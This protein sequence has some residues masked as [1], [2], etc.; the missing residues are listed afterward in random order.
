MISTGVTIDTEAAMTAANPL[1]KDDDV[2][3]DDDE[4]DDDDDE[5]AEGGPKFPSV[6]EPALCVDGDG[7]ETT[8]AAVAAVREAAASRK[9]KR[10]TAMLL[11]K[12]ME[13]LDEIWMRDNPVRNDEDGNPVD[14]AAG[15]AGND[16]GGG[17]EKQPDESSTTT[18]HDLRGEI[19]LPP[20]DMDRIRRTT[21][22]LVRVFREDIHGPAVRALASNEGLAEEKSRLEA[23]LAAARKDVDRLR[24]T[25]LRSR[26]TIQVSVSSFVA[27]GSNACASCL[28]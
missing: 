28:V 11:K 16:G 7:S 27:S 21:D 23:E 20:S 18:T 13:D 24:K 4:N 19:L 3:D 1:R 25:E 22:L 2:D 6:E 5:T 8:N 14:D 26:D 9:R 12:A 17:G 15:A 10:P